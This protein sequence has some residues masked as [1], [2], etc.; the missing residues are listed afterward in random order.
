[1]E[2]GVGCWLLV[3]MGRLWSVPIDLLPGSGC[4]DGCF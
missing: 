2:I 3:V 4:M 1:M